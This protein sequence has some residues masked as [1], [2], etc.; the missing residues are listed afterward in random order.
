MS[1][2]STLHRAPVVQGPSGSDWIAVLGMDGRLLY[3]H[4]VGG[5][6]FN[7]SS[8]RTRAGN[9]CIADAQGSVPVLRTP[10]VEVQFFRN[11]FFCGNF[12]LQKS[13]NS[14]QPRLGIAPL[15]QF[16]G[17]IA[18]FGANPLPGPLP[19]GRW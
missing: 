11:N 19:L 18:R 6:M 9:R 1:K 15:A 5:S 14:H 13:W 12:V 16:R 10:P 8:R 3:W 4:G 17:P 7:S 2:K